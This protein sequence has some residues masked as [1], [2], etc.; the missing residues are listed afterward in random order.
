MVEGISYELKFYPNGWSDG[1]D[2]HISVGITRTKLS[3]LN[4]D[5]SDKVIY[6][7]TILHSSDRQKDSK[8]KGYDDWT[9][10]E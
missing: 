8:M 3:C 4:L 10:K 7:I 9:D 6:I 5:T 1:K 2:T